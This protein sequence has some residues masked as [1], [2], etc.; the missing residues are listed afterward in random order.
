[1][2][3]NGHGST[4]RAWANEQVVSSTP[5]CN[6][7]GNLGMC[8]KQKAFVSRRIAGKVLP[9]VIASDAKHRHASDSLMPLPC[10][11]PSKH[12]RLRHFG[13]VV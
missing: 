2:L 6:S 5:L 3:I 8:R 9:H 12:S 4:L 11:G 7:I 10:R 1:M 13:R